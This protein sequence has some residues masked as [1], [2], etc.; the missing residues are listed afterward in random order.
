MSL[1]FL[2]MPTC[3]DVAAH[4]TDYMEGAL[5]PRQWLAVRLHLALCRMCRVYLDQLG[6]TASLL[7]GVAL[8]PPAAE[9]EERIM[10]A[11]KAAPRT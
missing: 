3:R 5:P 10:A 2:G 1:R 4:A 11:A 8:A 7:R 6:R 9:V